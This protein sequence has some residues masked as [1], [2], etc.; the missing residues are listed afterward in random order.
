LRRQLQEA[1]A[2]LVKLKKEG[3]FFSGMKIDSMTNK[4]NSLKQ[5]IAQY[6]RIAKSEVNP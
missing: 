5:Q 4:I 2:K 6:E 1:Q 3:G